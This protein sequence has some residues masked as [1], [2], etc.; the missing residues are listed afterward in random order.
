MDQ[1]MVNDILEFLLP[2][3]APTFLMI[4]GSHA[5]RTN[6]IESDLDIAF[7]KEN[8]DFTTY[9]L[10]M[11][12]QEL[13]DHLKIEV[14]LVNLREASTVFAAQIFSDGE[15]IYSRDDNIRI[16]EQMKALSMYVKLNEDRAELLDRIE[17]RGSVYEK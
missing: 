2:K 12:S 14:D 9:E 11:L 7:Y 1:R 6:R 5:K 15:V 17:E 8:A 13:A 4:F 16:R 10:F 3:L